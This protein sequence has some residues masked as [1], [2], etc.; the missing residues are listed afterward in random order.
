M[1]VLYKYQG[2]VFVKDRDYFARRPPLCGVKRSALVMD[3]LDLSY[4]FFS[5]S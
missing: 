4:Q 3:V 2:D 1:Q 5:F